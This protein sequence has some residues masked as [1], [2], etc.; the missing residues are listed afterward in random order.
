M[1]SFIINLYKKN[2][3]IGKHK[4]F[5]SEG[6]SPLALGDVSEFLTEGF[7]Y[8]LR[9]MAM[10]NVCPVDIMW[11]IIDVIEKH[12]KHK[13]GQSRKKDHSLDIVASNIFCS[14]FGVDIIE[15]KFVAYV[16]VYDETF[17]N[18]KDMYITDLQRCI[19]LYRDEWMALIKEYENER[20]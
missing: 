12:G 6:G 17:E 16:S 1:N 19:D 15:A 18:W 10:A 11:H 14:A 9:K 8:D 5:L 7:L 20:E 2:R 13:R 3:T 4:E